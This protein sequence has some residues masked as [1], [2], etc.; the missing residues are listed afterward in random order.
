MDAEERFAEA[1]AS[2]VRVIQV[3]IRLEKFFDL[4][5]ISGHDGCGVEFG[6]IGFDAGA[7][8]AFAYGGA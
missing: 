1:D 3:Q 2:G 8:G 5:C 7:C 6:P 4:R